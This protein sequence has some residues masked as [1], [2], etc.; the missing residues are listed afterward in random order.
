MLN[1]DWLGT[2]THNSPQLVLEFSNQYPQNCVQVA[3]KLLNVMLARHLVDD[4]LGIVV[5]QSMD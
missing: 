2:G 1:V 5:K 3:L 4:T